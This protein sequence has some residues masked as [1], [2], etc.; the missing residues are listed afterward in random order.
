L[1]SCEKH[2][3]QSTFDP[4]PSGHHAVA[5]HFL[6]GEAEVGGAVR[7]E[8]VELDERAG[9]KEH[10]EALAPPVILPFFVL[11]LDAVRTTALL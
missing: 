4:P 11:S 1:K 5:E 8:A 10:V 7:D 6:I 9:I 2:V 3:H